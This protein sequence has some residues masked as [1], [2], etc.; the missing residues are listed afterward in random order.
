VEPPPAGAEGAARLRALVSDP[1]Y[2][3]K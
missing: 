2:Q 1:V 3:L